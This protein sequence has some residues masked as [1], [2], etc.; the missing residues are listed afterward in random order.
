MDLG[1]VPY[2]H[3]AEIQEKMVRMRAAGALPNTLLLAEHPSTFTIGRF[4]RANDFKVSRASLL[5]QGLAICQSD[6][7]GGVIYHGPGQ[8]LVYPILGLKQLGLSVSQYVHSL[9]E[10]ALQV[11]EAFNIQGQRKPGYPGIWVGAAKIGFIGLHISCGISK[12]GL[13]LNVN[14]DLRYFDYID[15][16]GIP[17]VAVT[18]MAELCGASLEMSMVKERVLQAFQSVFPFKLRKASHVSDG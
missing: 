6:R 8:L 12:H 9:E 3:A 17:Q 14:T 10:V 13:A 5:A 7:G 2:S 15:S 4:K 1:L 18:S 16:C 11:L